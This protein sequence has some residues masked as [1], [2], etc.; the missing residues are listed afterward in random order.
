MKTLDMPKRAGFAASGGMGGGVSLNDIEK[1]KDALNSAFV[2]ND[3]FNLVARRMD[4]LERSVG[5]VV[6]K[7][8]S[9]I[10]KL[11]SLDRIRNS[12]KSKKQL[13]QQNPN[14][15]MP[16]NVVEID[17]LSV[18]ESEVQRNKR[19]Q[20]SLGNNAPNLPLGMPSQSLEQTNEINSRSR[21]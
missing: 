5:A 3:E 21:K 4:K 13:Q 15:L 2:G 8:D 19:L 1:I 6:G 17:A 10:R 18:D 11:E 20:D 12:K 7:I 16:H 9:I 14:N